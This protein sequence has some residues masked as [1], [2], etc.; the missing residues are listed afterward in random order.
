VVGET[1]DWGLND[2]Y[3]STVEMPHVQKALELALTQDTVYEGQCGG[4]ASMTCH[5][6]TGGTGTSSRV[7]KGED[8]KEYVVGALIQSNYGHKEYLQI[9]GVPIGKLLLKEQSQSEDFKKADE[10][11]PDGGSIVI[12]IFTDAPMVPH[13]LVRLAQRAGV[14]LSQVGGHGIGRNH[15][16][17]I[18]LAI[19]TANKPDEQ[20]SGP[21][22]N[23]KQ[24]PIEVNQLEAMR[25][26]CVDSI[27]QAASEAT[28]EAILNSLVAARAGRTGFQGV[29][30]D[31]LP[32]DRVKE[33]LKKHLVDV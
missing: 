24:P 16:G 18:F 26:E 12:M 13:Q 22:P 19:S 20:L 29:R 1:A 25:N 28:E 6:F 21:E 5:Q 8:G 10:K 32:V 31:G 23:F 2:I 33:L 17:D 27:F 14:G 11:H 15:S 3:H 4:G 7:I 9:G 30:A